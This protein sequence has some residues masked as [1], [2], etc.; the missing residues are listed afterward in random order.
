MFEQE[1]QARTLERMEKAAWEKAAPKR[2]EEERRQQRMEKAAEKKAASKVKN[3]IWDTSMHPP[4]CRVIQPAQL[5]D[6]PSSPELESNTE[7]ELHTSEVARPADLQPRDQC[8]STSLLMYIR[9][10]VERTSEERLRQVSLEH[11]PSLI[12]A[13]SC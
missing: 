12:R 13:S 1:K 4:P 8:C 6:E 3:S 9:R 7:S 10:E 5:L 2:E 11:T